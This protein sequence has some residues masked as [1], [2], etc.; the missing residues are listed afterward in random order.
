M[1][2]SCKKSNSGRRPRT[3]C[4]DCGGSLIRRTS[5]S[6]HPLLRTILMRC[7][8]DECGASFVAQ[9]ELV[10]RLSPPAAP[11]P[12]IDLPYRRGAARAMRGAAS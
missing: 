9:E 10:A 1:E 7:D 6:V 2:A 5:S 4:P 3:A 8:N 12:E 11:N